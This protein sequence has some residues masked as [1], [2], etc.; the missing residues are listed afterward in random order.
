MSLNLAFHYKDNHN[1]IK[2]NNN[3][4]VDPLSHVFKQSV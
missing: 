2:N 1:V 4:K 3:N